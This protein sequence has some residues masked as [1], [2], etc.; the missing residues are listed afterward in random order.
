MVYT[1]P[2]HTRV[3]Q[4][5]T[6]IANSV[7]DNIEKNNGIYFPQ[8]ILEGIP[9]H[10]A[11]DNTDFSNDTPDGKQEFHG[12]GQ[13]VFQKKKEMEREHLKIERSKNGSLKFKKDVFLPMK[14][15][16]KPN[17]PNENVPD[18]T[19]IIPCDEL[20]IYGLCDQMWTTCSISD[21]Q[22]P[23]WSAYNSLVTNLLD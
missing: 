17:P 19:G 14:S 10:F 3:L 11:I 7:A 16:Y 12:T 5:E 9:I 13:V 18:F 22:M 15:C 1:Y 2:F 4:I 6:G 23:T 8:N 21:D 20:E